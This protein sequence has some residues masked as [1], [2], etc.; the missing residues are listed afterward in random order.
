MVVGIFGG[1][2]GRSGLDGTIADVAF[3]ASRI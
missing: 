3:L 1:V 2:S